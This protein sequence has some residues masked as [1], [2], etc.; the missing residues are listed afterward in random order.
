MHKLYSTSSCVLWLVQ[1]HRWCPWLLL[2]VICAHFPWSRPSTFWACPS[3][4][5]EADQW[6]ASRQ[7]HFCSSCFKVFYSLID[8]LL[9][10]GARSILTRL[11]V[12]DLGRFDSFYQ[13]CTTASC[14]SRVQSLNGVFIHL[15]LLLSATWLNNA[16]WLEAS[17][18]SSNVHACCCMSTPSGCSYH[19]IP[20]FPLPFHLRVC[21]CL[22]M[23]YIYIN[24]NNKNNRFLIAHANVSYF[25]YCTPIFVYNWKAHHNC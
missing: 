2:F 19:V 15:T 16:I 17:N 12:M 13:Q 25:I 7:L 9:T 14:S 20:K 24:Q 5:R 8:F 4:R 6:S 18:L 1:I 11:P 21:V 3:V 10:H 23:W 22:C